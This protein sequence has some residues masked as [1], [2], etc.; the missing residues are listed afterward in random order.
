MAFSGTSTSKTSING[1]DLGTRLLAATQ[2]RLFLP[3]ALLLLP[4]SPLC[5][6]GL[7][8]PLVCVSLFLLL[9]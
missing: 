8:F 5:L 6:L 4:L 3:L 2:K 9:G 1:T 7:F